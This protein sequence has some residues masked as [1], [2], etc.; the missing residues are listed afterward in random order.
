LCLAIGLGCLAIFGESQP[1]GLTAVTGSTPNDQPEQAKKSCKLALVETKCGLSGIAPVELYTAM[2]ESIVP[3][4]KGYGFPLDIL[5]AAYEFNDQGGEFSW[6][7]PSFSKSRMEKEFS[8][9]KRKMT[10]PENAPVLVPANIPGLG[11][12]VYDASLIRAFVATSLFPYPMRVIAHKKGG[13]PVSYVKLDTSAARFTKTGLCGIINNLSPSQVPSGTQGTGGSDC[14]E[15]KKD[16]ATKP[17]ERNPA[18]STNMA[19][20]LLPSSNNSAKQGSGSVDPELAALLASLPTDEKPVSVSWLS[21]E[22]EGCVPWSTFTKDEQARQRPKYAGDGCIF[23][24]VIN[25]P[26][27]AGNSYFEISLSGSVVDPPDGILCG[28]PDLEVKTSVES[29]DSGPPCTAGRFHWT[30]SGPILRPPSSDGWPQQF[31]VSIQRRSGK[32]EDKPKL[33]LNLEG[34]PK[35]FLRYWIAG[36]T[37]ARWCFPD[38]CKL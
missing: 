1:A 23:T 8:A 30:L 24:F 28:P 4:G 12:Q 19:S 31:E 14:Q 37:T 5:E 33:E 2:E 32:I 11:P 25:I 3:I 26:R 29:V 17:T 20:H 6:R 16:D 38:D 10:E 34:A 9:A 13:A 36:R 27:L 21:Q 7:P 15:F 35:S 22:T 18:P